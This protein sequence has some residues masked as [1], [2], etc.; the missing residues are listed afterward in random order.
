MNTSRTYFGLSHFTFYYN[1]K[2]TTRG[3]GSFPSP[4][5]PPKTLLLNPFFLL[6]C[7]GFNP[8]PHKR[9]KYLHN[10]ADALLLARDIQRR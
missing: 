10:C 4:F 1:N 9:G 7:F 3:A 2:L 6:F 5:L 8:E